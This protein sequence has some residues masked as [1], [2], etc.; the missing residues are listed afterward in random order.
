MNRATLFFLCLVLVVGQ[1]IL[2]TSTSSKDASLGKE[3]ESP[4]SAESVKDTLP[5][6]KK[7]IQL[8]P[9]KKP[10]SQTLRP[11]HQEQKLQAPSNIKKLPDMKKQQ[12]SLV[13]DRVFLRENRVHVAIRNTQLLNPAAF[14]KLSLELKSGGVSR[15]WPISQV[16]KTGRLKTMNKEMVFDTGLILDKR[17]FVQ[18]S[19]VGGKNPITLKSVLAPEQKSAAKK[20]ALGKKPP[21]K[22]ERKTELRML[23]PGSAS[24]KTGG[25]GKKIQTSARVSPSQDSQVKKPLDLSIEFV[26]PEGGS[27]YQWGRTMVVRYRIPTPTDSG[28]VSFT[29]QSP[30]HGEMA[31][32]THLFENPLAPGEG[33]GKG[34]SRPGSGPRAETA[35]ANESGGLAQST[36]DLAEEVFEWRLPSGRD[37]PN[38]NDFIVRAQK[39][40]LIGRSAP[41]SIMTTCEGGAGQRVFF[42]TPPTVLRREDSV[43]V[44][45]HFCGCEPLHLDNV[46]REIGVHVH[47]SAAGI[48]PGGLSRASF[49]LETLSDDGLS[50]AM[51]VTI[52]DSEAHVPDGDSY[53]ITIA[54]DEDCLAHTDTFAVRGRGHSAVFNLTSPT[55]GDLFFRGEAIDIRCETEDRPLPE[56]VE[57]YLHCLEPPGSHE[58][59][60]YGPYRRDFLGGNFRIQVPFR[61]TNCERTLI[62]IMGTNSYGIAFGNQSPEF[63]IRANGGNLGIVVTSPR[64][65]EVFHPGETIPVRMEMERIGATPPEWVFVGLYPPDSRE[66]SLV[67]PSVSTPVLYPVLSLPWGAHEFEI[68]VDFNFSD[69]PVHYFQ[70]GVEG[71][72]VGFGISEMFRIEPP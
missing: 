18:V 15:S 23:R 48:D 34:G 56:E 20:L 3:A 43:R 25:S 50:G 44:L 57:I 7:S 63:T 14:S 10:G 47:D 68:P 52:P 37:L 21:V 32:K 4:K 9:E 42:D 54:N 5:A 72:G 66:G 70:I 46:Y 6:S 22:E 12:D 11:S 53:M 38:G 65:G 58:P 55:R 27:I 28:P 33:S 24:A 36:W 61:A 31:S 60:S 8:R 40:G 2:S 1:T 39:G 45:F 17:D 41:F 69:D 13:I 49:T 29:L 51:R 35:P 16:D 67:A 26:S 71:P 59:W 19:L 62:H 64:A 30:T